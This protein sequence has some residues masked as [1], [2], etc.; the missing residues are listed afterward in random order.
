MS[1]D[2]FE[3]SYRRPVRERVAG[4]VSPPVI[5]LT[6]LVLAGLSLGGFSLLNGSTYVPVGVN[7]LPSGV[8]LVVGGLVGVAFALLS[9]GLG[10]AASRRSHPGDPGWVPTAAQAAVV[11]GLLSAVLRLVATAV[12]ALDV[13]S[14][15]FPRL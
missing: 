12:S 11:L 6:A 7:G 10:F 3:D 15:G 9:V 4:Y 13:G 1:E 5:A 14:G 8:G 2:P